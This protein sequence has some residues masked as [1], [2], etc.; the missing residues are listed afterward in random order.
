ML[1]P[2][3]TVAV[4]LKYKY[5]KRKPSKHKFFFI[6]EEPNR[7]KICEPFSTRESFIAKFVDHNLNVRH[8]FFMKYDLDKVR[9]T[10]E[11][12]DKDLSAN[13][14][15]CDEL[16]DYLERNPLDHATT[17]EYEKYNHFVKEGLSSLRKLEGFLIRYDTTYIP[18]SEYPGEERD[19]VNTYP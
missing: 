17:R 8:S 18:K 9:S 2:L 12:L 15:K 13:I 10:I 3:K 7:N 6:D 16:Q 1:K 19:N 14:F 11:K 4:G 5:Y